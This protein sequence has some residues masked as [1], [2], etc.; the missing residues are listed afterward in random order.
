MTL[1]YK[2]F[3]LVLGVL[4]G[5]IAARLFTVVWGLIDDEEPPEPTTRDSPL[6]KVILAGALQGAVFRAT[7]TI[8]DRSGAS[9]WEHL[10]GVW[11]GERKPDR[12]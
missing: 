2:P 1:A 9:G 4:S 10:T 12:T 5:L 6:V 11:P 3:G 7:K 8:V